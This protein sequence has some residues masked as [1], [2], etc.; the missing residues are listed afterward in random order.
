MAE[1]CKE[2]FTQGKY[3]QLFTDLLQKLPSNQYFWK[4]GFSER[5]KFKPELDKIVDLFMETDGKETMDEI[6][7]RLQKISDDYEEAYGNPRNEPTYLDKQLYGKSGLYSRIGNMILQEAKNYPELLAKRNTCL[8]NESDF[9]Q[10]NFETEIESE[11]LI[12][13]FD[14]LEMS[15][16]QEENAEESMIYDDVL[17]HELLEESHEEVNNIEEQIKVKQ[18]DI[19]MN[20]ALKTLHDYFTEREESKDSRNLK[21]VAQL[22]AEKESSKKKFGVCS[23][24]KLRVIN[25]PNR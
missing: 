25:L 22:K 2:Q 18:S 7:P 16:P 4:Y 24:M 10:F 17:P 14:S 20:Q 19:K 8:M 6:I 23:Y 11:G 9:E 21:I 13:P 5:H 15:M 12:E 1:S 3:E